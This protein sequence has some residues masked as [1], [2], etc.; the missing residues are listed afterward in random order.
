MAMKVRAVVQD[1]KLVPQAPLGLPEGAEVEVIVEPPRI[2]PP[3]VTDPEEKARRMAELVERMQRHPIPHEAPRL[4]FSR[5]W[6]HER[7]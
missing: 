3:T 2:R 6:M 7:R 4:P 1:G 5:E